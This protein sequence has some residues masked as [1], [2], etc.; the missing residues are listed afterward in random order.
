MN[1]QV[2]LFFALPCYVLIAYEI[3][4]LNI[5]AFYILFAPLA[6]ETL[7]P[8]PSGFARTRSAQSVGEHGALLVEIYTSILPSE[9]D[10]K[11]HLYQI[12]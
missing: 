6:R 11:I 3:V 5:Q 7:S 10:E 12:R 4:R 2:L 1:A 8:N 9:V